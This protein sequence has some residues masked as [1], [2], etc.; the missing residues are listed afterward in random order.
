MCLRPLRDSSD[1]VLV[2][3]TDLRANPSFSGQVAEVE[4]ALEVGC[5]ENVVC[6]RQASIP[7]LTTW[8]DRFGKRSAKILEDSRPLGTTDTRSL[9]LQ[10][11]GLDSR[12][13]KGV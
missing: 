4:V 2:G 12:G 7:P 6:L 1:K 8:I 5:Q 3:P 11:R 10:L 13:D 9:G